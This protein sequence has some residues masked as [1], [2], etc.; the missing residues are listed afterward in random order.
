MQN[1][2]GTIL[3]EAVRL[4]LTHFV[5]PCALER[6][7]EESSVHP[8]VA[9]THGRVLRTHHAEVSSVRVEPRDLEAEVSAPVLE[10]PTAASAAATGCKQQIHDRLADGPI[11][12]EVAVVAGA[13]RNWL[14]MW[15]ATSDALDL[16][17]GRTRATRDCPPAAGWI[18]ELGLP[19][20]R[21]QS[22]ST[23][24]RMRLAPRPV[25][26]AR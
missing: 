10:V 21:G 7:R 5:G 26:R 9:A 19:C 4:D 20:V 14:N 15:K 3:D 17:L 16:V 23:Y 8:P 2:E 24:V 11:A 22:L 25:G 12:L 18:N 6:L 13:R 1:V